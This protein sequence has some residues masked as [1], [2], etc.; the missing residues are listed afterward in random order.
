MGVWYFLILFIG[1]FLV[2]KGLIGRKR[3]LFVCLGVF[4]VLFSLFM[5][6]PGSDEM[7]AELLHLN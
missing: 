6:S 5:F 3:I 7:I 4:C 2:G 1:L